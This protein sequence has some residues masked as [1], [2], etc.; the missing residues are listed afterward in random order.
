MFYLNGDV[1]ALQLLLLLLLTEALPRNPDWAG[2]LW[3]GLPERRKGGPGDAGR[4]RE[5]ERC[6]LGEGGACVR[7][8]WGAGG[9]LSRCIQRL[10]RGRGGG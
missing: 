7:D 10:L 3:P 8:V 2:L 4:L 5:A 6:W 9:A 1:A